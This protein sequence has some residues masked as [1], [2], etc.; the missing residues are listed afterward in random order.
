MHQT[1]MGPLEL[2]ERGRKGKWPGQTALDLM[3]HKVSALE[4]RGVLDLT[5]I[6]IFHV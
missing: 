4:K 5:R 3:R 2:K 6:R 1:P